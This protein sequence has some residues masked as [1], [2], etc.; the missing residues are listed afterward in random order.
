ML[1]YRLL[2]LV[3]SYNCYI[4][5]NNKYFRIYKKLLTD[6]V[7]KNLAGARKA[8]RF[9]KIEKLAKYTLKF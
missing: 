7:N 3:M 5:N 1:P 2:L 9:Q 6:L 8:D 4:S